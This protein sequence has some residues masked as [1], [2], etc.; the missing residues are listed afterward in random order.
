M[1]NNNLNYSRRKL[2]N[3]KN[4]IVSTDNYFSCSTDNIGYSNYLGGNL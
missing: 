4:Q 3:G 1:E 2:I